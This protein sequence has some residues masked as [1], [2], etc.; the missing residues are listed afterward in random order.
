[1]KI[2]FF[3]RYRNKQM[4]SYVYWRVRRETL[5]IAL[6]ICR[7]TLTFVNVSIFYM[8]WNQIPNIQ[9]VPRNALFKYEACNDVALL[10]Y[11]LYTQHD[12]VQQYIYSH[13][14]FFM[15]TVYAEIKVAYSILP[16][17][18]Y[19]WYTLYNFASAVFQKMTVAVNSSG[20]EI[21]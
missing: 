6:E 14:N 9:H 8:I 16:S 12:E 1:M 2:F 20:T 15:I 21:Y 10:I 7:S 5:L 19:L 17:L 18:F 13:L 3:Q 4:I 11:I